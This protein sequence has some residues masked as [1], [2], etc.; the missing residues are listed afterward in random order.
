MI[1]TTIT[2]LWLVGLVALVI[3]LAIGGVSLGL[4]LAYGGTYTPAL[5]GNGYDFNPTINSYFWTTL[6]FMITG[7]TIAA[8]GGVMQLAAWIGALVNTY[9]LADKTWFLA[10]LICGLVG[11]AVS[12]IGFGAMVAYLVAGPDGLRQAAPQ[13]APTGAPPR[14]EESPLPRTAPIVHAH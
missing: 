14:L 9:Q 13:L 3:G 7:F 11:L 1:K 2:R 4:M 12:I 10:L 6:G 8:A 5:S